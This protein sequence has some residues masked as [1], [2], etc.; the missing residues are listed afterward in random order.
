MEQ[1]IRAMPEGEF[2]ELIKRIPDIQQNALR[3]VRYLN[4]DFPHVARIRVKDVSQLGVQVSRHLLEWPD[5]D[6]NKEQTAMKLQL[7]ALA[8]SARPDERLFE[9]HKPV[10]KAIYDLKAA[11]EEGRKRW[12]Q[13]LALEAEEVSARL[14]NF[15]LLGA[16]KCATTWLYNCLAAHP[17]VY[18]PAEKELEFFGSFRYY[19]GMNWYKQHFV[20]WTDEKVGGDMSVGYFT[21]VEAPIRMHQLLD[22]SSLKLLL[23]LREPLSRALSYYEYRL[24]SGN[25]PRSFKKS[26]DMWYF[27]NLYIESGHYYKYYKHYLNYFPKERILILLFEEIQQNPRAALRKVFEFLEVQPDY[28]AEVFDKKENVGRSIRNLAL[29]YWLYHTGVFFQAKLPRYG[30]RIHRELKQLNERFNLSQERQPWQID[31][32]VYQHLKEEFRPSNRQLEELS[33]VDLSLWDTKLVKREI[34]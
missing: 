4:V 2:L 16:P 12:Q 13:Y 1:A 24:L 25:A 21:S 19:L 10:T 3:V 9:P 14:P 34:A 17:E 31:E 23:L 8:G 28:Y 33:G 30:D 7:L 6:G 26:L 5:E 18:V 29:Y 20:N 32:G 22:S 15:V 27:R 11:F